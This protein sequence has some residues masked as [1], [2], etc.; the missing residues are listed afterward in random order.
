MRSSLSR[1]SL[2]GNEEHSV[3]GVDPEPARLVA[4]GDPEGDGG[5]PALVG[6]AHL[7]PR[8]PRLGRGALV[9]A[10]LIHLA[11]EDGRVVVDVGQLGGY[12]V[13]L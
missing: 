1:L 10:H 11:A 7:E 12:S 8:Q 9:H 3:L 4:G 13:V 2:P 6:V 5:V